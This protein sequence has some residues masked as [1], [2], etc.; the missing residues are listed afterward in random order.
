[1]PVFRELKRRNVPRMAALYAVAAWLIVQGDWDMTT[2]FSCR[3][4]GTL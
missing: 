3:Q 2:M 1:M 4:S